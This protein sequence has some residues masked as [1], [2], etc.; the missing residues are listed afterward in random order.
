MKVA[1]CIFMMPSLFFKATTALSSQT[2]PVRT[3][4]C[5]MA[6]Y[7][8]VHEMAI[9]T[10]IRHAPMYRDEKL[11][12]PEHKPNKSD[13]VVGGLQISNR[14][15]C[16]LMPHTAKIEQFADIVTTQHLDMTPAMLEVD[17]KEHVWHLADTWHLTDTR[18]SPEVDSP[19]S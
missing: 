7:A 17:W 2:F 10:S 4:S 12:G 16:H 18:R 9:S 13:H 15:I 1:V 5:A 6:S 11:Q 14:P 19:D 8:P 3:S